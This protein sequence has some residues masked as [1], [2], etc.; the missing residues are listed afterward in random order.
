MFTILKDWITPTV[1]K[2]G[3]IVL[4]VSG[5]YLYVQ[6]L[7]SENSRLVQDNAKLQVGFDEQKATIKKLEEDH[8]LIV[9]SKDELAKKVL[10]LIFQGDELK[11]TLDRPGKSKSLSDLA[12]KK[13]G[14]VEKA[15]NSGTANVFKCFENITNNK[16]C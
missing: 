16:P 11:K 6:H 3:F 14:L 12:I 9:K 5:L 10:E 7:R 4:T 15:I 13:P 2:W 8:A 1:L